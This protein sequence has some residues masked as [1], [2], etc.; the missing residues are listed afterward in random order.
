[1]NLAKRSF[2]ALFNAK[3]VASNSGQLLS[4]E[5]VQKCGISKREYSGYEIT[6]SGKYLMRNSMTIVKTESEN[7]TVNWLS[8]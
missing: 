8:F 4:N 7:L 1:M 5:Q 2:R 6:N 3:K